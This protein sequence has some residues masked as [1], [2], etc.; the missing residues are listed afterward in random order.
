MKGQGAFV[1]N[2]YC[3][4]FDE[5]CSSAVNTV[6]S[7]L[8]EYNVVHQKERKRPTNPTIDIWQLSYS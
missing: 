8:P 3:I 4:A 1:D 6:V 7:L 5:D 2:Q